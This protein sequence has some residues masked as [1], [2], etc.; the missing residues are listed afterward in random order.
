LLQEDRMDFKDYYSTLGV[1]RTATQDEIKR[2][3]R[4]LARKFHPDVS[5]EPNAEARFKEVAEAHEAL[6]D[7]ERRAAYD[8]LAAR[9]ASGQQYEPPPGWDSGYEFRGR[10][11][12]TGSAT[13][14]EDFSA[15][16]ESIFGRAGGAARGRR[17]GAARRVEGQDHHARIEI[18]LEDAY[19]GAR[20]TITLRR[21]VIDAQGQSS[22][23]ERR[24]EVNIPR[25]VRPGQHLRLAAQGDAGEGGAA[26][27]DLYLEIE[28]RPH[29]RFR[30]DGADVW[31]DLPLAPWEAALGASVT[32]ST[33]EGEVQ[34]NVP[35]GSSA[36]RKLRLKGRGLPGKVHGD[37]YVVLQIAL[38]AADDATARAA[39]AAL[40]AAFP[41]FD[42][43]NS[44]GA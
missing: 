37:L 16:F 33:P 28:F 11:D 14:A 22:V 31:A 39:Y 1:A 29:K 12:S 27:G 30:L 35:A 8:D 42:A 41:H 44:E 38:P 26:A 9:H 3:Y 40:A 17:G 24:L 7:P 34:L 19:R 36:G 15:F 10:G 43:R 2:A 18:D 4:K 20:H 5:K 21:P 25:G 23:H 32:A 6:I 13:G